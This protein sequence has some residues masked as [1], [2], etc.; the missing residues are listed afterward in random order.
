MSVPV[1]VVILAA[2]QGK[3]MHSSL[4]KVL[5][6]LAG[7]P[8]V[9]HVIDAAATLKP[10]AM[11]LVVGHGSESVRETLAQANL[12]YAKQDPP[13]GTGDAVR[14][15]LPK[16]PDDGVTLIVLGDVP[17][18]SR[19]ALKA[20]VAS[21]KRGHVGLLTART[22]QPDGLGRI[23]RDARGDVRAIVEQRDATPEEAAID[24]INTGVMAARTDKLARWVHALNDDNDQREFYLTDVIAMAVADGVRVE[25]HI[26]ADARDVA[27]VNDRVQLVAAERL[28]QQ[29]RAE[30]LMRDGTWIADPA[31]FDLRG[32]LRC[33]RDVRIDVGCVIEG[34]VVLGDEVSIGPYC[35]LKDVDIA[36]RTSIAAFSQLEGSRIGR[37]CRVGPYARLRPGTILDDE[38][39]I[40]NFV[41]VKAS[42]LG[43]R[44]KANHLAY[45]GDAVLGADVNFGAGSITANYDGANKHRTTIEANAH[46]GSNCVLV[47]PVTIGEGATIGG[48]STIARDAPPASLT[49]TRAPQVSVAGWTRSAK[50]KA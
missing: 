23:L 11:C 10:R 36:N 12:V 21:A 15:A 28:L 16:L 37:G 40:G 50:K 27:G 32:E 29:R 38:V 26:A 22:P 46:I 49:L 4:P 48:G 44:A 13:R 17:L 19:D 8:M 25:A 20:V 39:H 47:A 30:S 41:E 35:V 43:L 24:E 9:A 33:G 1:N 18:V 7:R 2:G 42:T 14:C 3:R 34:R 5:H 45:V 6:S 31:R